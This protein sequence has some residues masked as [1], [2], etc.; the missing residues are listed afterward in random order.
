MMLGKHFASEPFGQAPR[1]RAQWQSGLTPRA[2]H[3][4]SDH[5]SITSMLKNIIPK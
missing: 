4:D 2:Q 1:K 5:R 3:A